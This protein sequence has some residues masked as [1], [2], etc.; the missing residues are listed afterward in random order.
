MIDEEL[1][2][3]NQERIYLDYA[4]TAP[5]DSRVLDEMIPYLKDHFGNAS[6]LC[7]EG[8]QARDAVEAAR[9]TIARCIGVRD[10]HEVIFTSGGTE[11]DNM[12]VIGIA[13][14]RR[15]RMSKSKGVGHVICSAFEHKAVLEAAYSL[16]AEGIEV[17]EVFP[18]KDGFIEPRSVDAAI[19]PDTLVV[20]VMAANNEIGTVQPISDIAE[21]VH[22]HGVPLHVD[23]V[24]AF[25][26]TNFIPGKCGADCVT[27]A[28]HKICGP[29]GIGALYLSKKIPFVPIIH[30]GGQQRNR[31]SGT[32]DLASI[33]GFAKAVELIDQE[34]KDK[35]LSSL[36]E[37]RDFFVSEIS[38]IDGF[39]VVVDIPKKNISHHIATLI[40][41]VSDLFESEELVMELDRRGFCVSGGS[42][43]TAAQASASHVLLSMGIS[44][45]IASRY[46]R[47]S[48]GRFTKIEELKALVAALR[49]LSSVGVI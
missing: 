42:A 4:A 20:S 2:A 25:G 19:R 44:K 9:H 11:S 23:G 30:G 33:V 29:L 31:R 7:T 3:P 10:P 12:A 27:I 37:M 34:I 18:N 16:K 32:Y 17:T 41:I 43:C 38:K 21:V 45:D 36:M 8:R 1:C 5:L 24:A 39:R 22:A 40:P 14:A 46:L 15:Q 47:I 48:F 49:D 28:S 35:Q 6:A 13:R 26:K